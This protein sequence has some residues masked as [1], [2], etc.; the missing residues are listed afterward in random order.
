MKDERR[1]RDEY[2]G[3]SRENE[4]KRIESGMMLNTTRSLGLRHPS[5]HNDRE[6][7]FLPKL[8]Y[9]S[10]HVKFNA[11]HTPTRKHERFVLVLSVSDGTSYLTKHACAARRAIAISGQDFPVGCDFPFLFPKPQN[12]AFLHLILF[13]IGRRDGFLRQIYEGSAYRLLSEALCCKEHRYEVIDSEDRLVASLDLCFEP[14]YPPP[15]IAANASFDPPVVAKKYFKATELAY[16]QMQRRSSRQYFSY[17]KRDIGKLPM[18]AFP[19]ACSTFPSTR[20]SSKLL[21]SILAAAVHL[22][23]V[24]PDSDNPLAPLFILNEATT[25]LCRALIYELDSVRPANGDETNPISDFWLQP[26]E[27]PHTGIAAYDCDDGAAFTLEVIQLIKRTQ[28][29]RFKDHPEM[30]RLL[31]SL[32]L[33]LQP[34][35]PCMTLGDLRLG[36]TA[37]SMTAH[38]YTTLLD[39]RYVDALLKNAM[40]QLPDG[41][42]P[43]LVLESTNWTQGVRSRHPSQKEAREMIA[44]NSLRTLVESLFELQPEIEWDRMIKFRMNLDEVNHVKLYGTV[45]ALLTGDHLD[46]RESAHI[47]LAEHDTIGLS[48]EQLISYDK[49]ASA[50]PIIHIKRGTDEHREF[51]SNFVYHSPPASLYVTRNQD[52]KRFTGAPEKINKPGAIQFAMRTLDWQEYKATI[53]GM[54]EEW[55]AKHKTELGLTGWTEQ[56]FR[57]AEYRQMKIAGYRFSS[58][59]SLT[60][61]DIH[62]RELSGQTQSK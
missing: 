56:E 39:S 41:L 62:S 50:K 1:E 8:C 30:H 51:E 5:R 10:M 37:D 6:I 28:P 31:V 52:E 43:A 44:Y 4:D 48:L 22:S 34:Y 9:S 55:I 20:D 33:A 29:E 58:N 49:K 46:G 60:V 35:T 3:M 24:K 57:F 59:L 53:T 17:V 26:S 12:D 15:G 18:L 25:V 32:Q 23:S 38:A 47:L 61:I 14:A 16:K 40:D 19:M 11:F 2:K 54:L 27:F 45:T 7:Q 42:S 21:H 36:L 13:S